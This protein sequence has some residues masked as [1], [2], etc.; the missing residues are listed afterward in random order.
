MCAFVQLH[1]LYRPSGLR[2]SAGRISL[3]HPHGPHQQGHCARF[4]RCRHRFAISLASTSCHRLD[5]DDVPAMSHTSS[6][7]A[8]HDFEV[9]A[10]KADHLRDRNAILGALAIDVCEGLIATANR[11]CRFAR[12][13]E[14]ERLS[15]RDPSAVSTA[16]AISVHP[17]SVSLGNVLTSEGGIYRGEHVPVSTPIGDADGVHPLP[18][19]ACSPMHWSTPSAE[20]A[21]NSNAQS[22]S[23]QHAALTTLPEDS[24]DFTSSM[25]RVHLDNVKS[26]QSSLKADLADALLMLVRK[27]SG[28]DSNELMSKSAMLFSAHPSLVK[29]L[30][31]E[32]E[33]DCAIYRDATGMYRSL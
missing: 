23:T 1:L 27:N 12:S 31:D 24:D 17:D 25:P 28:I 20:V 19:T 18:T 15:G 26:K 16:S 32:L 9:L 13:T 14:P 21:K 11:S 7:H 10:Q 3:D 30:V 6:G 4:A 29:Q 33:G 22:E 8:R 2:E 5:G